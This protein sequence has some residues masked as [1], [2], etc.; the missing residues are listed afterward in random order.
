MRSLVRWS[1]VLLLGLSACGGDDEE[2]Q[3]DRPRTGQPAAQRDSVVRQPVF[4]EPEAAQIL[5]AINQNEIA[6]GRVARERSQNLDILRYAAVMI[7]DHEG[8]TQLIDSLL[9]PISDSVN[10]ESRALRTAGTALV[11]T[12]WRMEGGFN[13]TYITQ[14]IAAH[15]QALL[16]LDTAIIPSARNPQLKKLL[17]DLRPAVVAHLLRAR[18]IW[19]ERQASGLAASTAAAARPAPSTQTSPPSPSATPA[20]MPTPPPAPPDTMPPVSTIDLH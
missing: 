9:P 11:D 3:G 5:R 20:P 15:E 6:T 10:A 7:A 17:R 19:A 13:N 18:Q 8:M 1:L 14:Q 16:L 4:P 2:E 12:L